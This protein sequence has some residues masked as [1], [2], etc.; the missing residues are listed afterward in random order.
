MFGVKNLDSSSYSDHEAVAAVI[1]VD[2]ESGL[3]GLCDGLELLCKYILCLS[4]WCHI[5]IEIVIFEYSISKFEYYEHSRRLLNEG[6]KDRLDL[7]C[8]FAAKQ[9]P[10][11]DA[12][13]KITIFKFT[14][15]TNVFSS[16]IT[17]PMSL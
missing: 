3:S 9:S 7:R 4:V 15:V 2:Q 11:L 13:K 8:S 10:L 16:V 17:T 12:Y 1:D 5:I 6:L 14:L